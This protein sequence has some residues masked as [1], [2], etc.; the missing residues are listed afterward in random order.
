M[1]CAPFARDPQLAAMMDRMA[2]RYGVLPHTLG[3]LTDAELA[4]CLACMAAGEREDANMAAEVKA[5]P[6]VVVAGR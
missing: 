4:I 1:R 3:H 6:V 5:W 2:R